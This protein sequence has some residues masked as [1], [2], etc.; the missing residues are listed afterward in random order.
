MQLIRYTYPRDVTEFGDQPV[1]VEDLE[2]RTLVDQLQ[3]AVRVSPDDLAELP[4][5]QLVEVAEQVGAEVPK[6][7]LKGQFVKAIAE[8]QEPQ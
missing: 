4:K 8:A 5:A 7:G 2:A 6:R 1:L 3:R